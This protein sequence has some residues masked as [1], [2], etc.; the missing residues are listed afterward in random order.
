MRKMWRLSFAVAGSLI[1]CAAAFHI[2]A[3][4]EDAVA[5]T[6]P[7]GKL[8]AQVIDV[9]RAQTGTA[10]HRSMLLIHGGGWAAGSRKDFSDVAKWLARQ[11]ITAI[12][13]DYR[14]TP[15]GATWSD[16]RSDVV[17]A[18]WRAR[19][20]AAMLGID[21]QRLGG[22]GGSAGAQLVAYLGTTDAID[23]SGV[24][25]SIALRRSMGGSVGPVCK[26]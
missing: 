12:S 24:H 4:A 8:P 18:V 23:P 26:R 13:V 20:N 22:M 16:I 11:G 14:L 25:K 3:H 5:E 2:W 10:P 19:H 17:S 15:S 9:Y 6:Y 7:Y 21:P 1:A